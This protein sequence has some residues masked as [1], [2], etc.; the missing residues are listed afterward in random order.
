VTHRLATTKARRAIIS[1][2][3]VTAGSWRSRAIADE[4]LARLVISTRRHYRGSFAA[5][6]SGTIGDDPQLEAEKFFR[7]IVSTVRGAIK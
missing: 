4:S 3:T 7:R 5:T 6:K 1:S 2:A